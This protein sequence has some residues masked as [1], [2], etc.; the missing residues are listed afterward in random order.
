MRRIFLLSLFLV[1]LL[2]GQGVCSTTY[3]WSKISGTTYYKSGGWPTSGDTAGTLQQTFAAASAGDT[4][5]IDGGATSITYSGAADI[6]ATALWGIN[7]AMAFRTAISSDPDYLSH[8]GVATLDVN[9]AGPGSSGFNVTAVGVSF[10]GRAYAY[11]KTLRMG[12]SITTAGKYVLNGSQTATYNDIETFGQARSVADNGAG[13]VFN[14]CVLSHDKVNG[15]YLFVLAQVHIFNYC[16]FRDY[17]AL[18]SVTGASPVFNNC[19]FIGYSTYSISSSGTGTPIVN[20]SEAF[21][22][23]LSCTYSYQ[24]T[25]AGSLT[26]N[27]SMAYLCQPHPSQVSTGT[28][29]INNA[30]TVMQP[31]Y[32]RNR[33]PS[34]VIFEVDD[35]TNLDY[36]NATVAPKL[37][38]YGWRGTYNLYTNGVTVGQ[39]QTLNA[40]NASGHEIAA[41]TRF[42]PTLNRDTVNAFS[43]RYTG[44]DATAATWT[45]SGNTLTTTVTGAVGPDLNVDMTVVGRTTLATLAAYINANYPKYTA[46]QLNA[47]ANA[48]PQTTYLSDIAAQDINGVTHNTTLDHTRFWDGEILGSKSDII[49]NITGLDVNTVTFCAPS[50][51]WG[52]GTTMEDY[53][54]ANNF[55][56]ARGSTIA[57]Y[58][59]SA[60]NI[61]RIPF[62]ETTV[63]GSPGTGSMFSSADPTYAE[64]KSVYGSILADLG[65]QGGILIVFAHSLTEAST[66][67]WDKML[68]ETAVSGV[69]VMTRKQAIAYIKSGTD[70]GDHKNYTM[71][72]PDNLS[73]LPTVQSPLIM[74]GKNVCT[75]PVVPFVE[76]T[77]YMTGCY[78]DAAGLQVPVAGC[79]AVATGSI[80]PASMKIS[81]VSGGAQFI[82]FGAAGSLTPYLGYGL[83]VKDSAGKSL[84]ATVGAAGT[85]ETLDAESL[86]DW[87]NTSYDTFTSSGTAITSAIS[88]DQASARTNGGLTVQNALFYY[89]QTITQV[90][91]QSPTALIDAN[92]FSLVTGTGNRYFTAIQ[93][94]GTPVNDYISMHVT[95]AS[96]FSST[97][98]L[99]RVLTPSTYGV[100]ISNVSV[101]SGFSYNDATGY[102]YAIYPGPSGSSIGAYEP[103][104]VGPRKAQ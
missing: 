96:N 83:S 45:I 44:G 63:L 21:S 41:H 54:L 9:T 102:T 22:A 93:A 101:E 24:Q 60:I 71:V 47:D 27:N 66:A 90:S 6:G 53:L 56:G 39:W 43:L 88:A 78:T 31:L 75:A 28:V 69:Q 26:I 70:S 64:V 33:Y 23:P 98:S 65:E 7:K 48:S 94:F 81:N 29:I 79:I 42:H 49:A 17:K 59:L 32:V 67:L 36:F 86:V 55:Y 100:T 52:A 10:S 72:L 58:P 76:C 84:V 104:N 1:L 16:I 19:R 4:I 99:K 61:Y 37:E 46:A 34:I 13:F 3:Y 57:S 62:R 51:T 5:V 50:N 85:G 15:D 68:A 25:G 35:T 11:P 74:A 38:A 2:A 12:N 14:R 40:L 80:A 73:G 92:T 77:G 8:N 97:Q 95:R 82:D 87:G 91:G 103:W 20:N 30:P 89:A 18:L